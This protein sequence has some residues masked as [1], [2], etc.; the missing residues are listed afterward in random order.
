MRR[1]GLFVALCT[2]SVLVVGLLLGLAFR[3]PG[4]ARAIVVSGCL[5]IAVQIV[6]FAAVRAADPRRLMTMWGLGALVRLATLVVYGVLMLRPFH[7]APVPA[8]VSLAAFLFVTTLIESRLLV[9]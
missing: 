8:L 7:L 1:G 4:D 3:R 6:L 2:G 5:A 9:S